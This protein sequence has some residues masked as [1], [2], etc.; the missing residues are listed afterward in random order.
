MLNVAGRRSTNQA[1]KVL[2]LTLKEIAR[3]FN[4]PLLE[5]QAWAVCHLCA[6]KLVELQWPLPV[7]TCTEISMETVVITTEGSVELIRA[8]GNTNS[9]KQL[10]ELV[11]CGRGRFPA[12]TSLVVISVTSYAHMHVP[13]TVIWWR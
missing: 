12:I 10:Q 8:K 1:Q 2:G 5:E 11:L 6:C 4:S 3:Q 9:L 7:G 13:I